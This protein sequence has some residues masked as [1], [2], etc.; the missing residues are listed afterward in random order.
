MNV[1]VIFSTD[2]QIE[3]F[4][5]ILKHLENAGMTV[6]SDFANDR[7][8]YILSNS[9][10]YDHFI[11]VI[12]ANFG[13]SPKLMYVTATI[14]RLKIQPIIIITNWDGIGE[15]LGGAAMLFEEAKEAS[16]EKASKKVRFLKQSSIQKI[17]YS[18]KF[19][20]SFTERGDFERGLSAL[21]DVLNSVK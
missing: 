19:N 5:M 12:D 7:T 16:A 17:F 1:G 18:S 15:N 20:L 13:M 4:S 2:N 10:N 21:V 11:V 8:D 3:A 14:D 9:K 6:E